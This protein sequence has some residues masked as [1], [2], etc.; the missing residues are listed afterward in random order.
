STGEARLYKG[1]TGIVRIG[2][3]L[4]I[5]TVL[6]QR[7]VTA[8]LLSLSTSTSLKHL[9]MRQKWPLASPFPRIMVTDRLQ[10]RTAGRLRLWPQ[11]CGSTHRRD[12]GEQKP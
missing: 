1:A 12:A 7:V 4:G 6:V 3:T 8:P 9:S 2:K 5:G 11:R 10:R